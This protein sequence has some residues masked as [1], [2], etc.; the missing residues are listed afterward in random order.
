MK[1][2]L[3]VWGFFSNHVRPM[4]GGGNIGEPDEPW[5]SPSKSNFLPSSPL[6]PHYR[7]WVIIADDFILQQQQQSSQHDKRGRRRKDFH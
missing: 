1:S 5:I 3:H 6:R 2:I 7:R 4:S